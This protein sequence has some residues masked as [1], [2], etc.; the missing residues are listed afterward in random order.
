MYSNQSQL[1]HCI[2][3]GIQALQY[4]CYPMRSQ[5]AGLQLALE[6]PAGLI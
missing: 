6:L 5:L 2:V 3:P 1:L 4:H